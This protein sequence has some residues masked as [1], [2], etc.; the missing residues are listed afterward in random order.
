RRAFLLLQRGILRRFH[1][2]RLLAAGGQQH[3]AHDEEG[4]VSHSLAFTAIASIIKDM[5]KALLFIIFLLFAPAAHAQEDS[6]FLPPFVYYDLDG[7]SHDIHFDT[8]GQITFVHF[9]ATW[10]APCL[11]ELPKLNNFAKHAD[12]K[13]ARVI[14]IAVD[15]DPAKVSGFFRRYN[16]DALT[17]Y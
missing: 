2:I 11:R 9:W 7:G 6:M 5:K 4:K 12:P 3:H 8:P 10:C 17:P 14:A 16:I 13:R 15:S 1:I